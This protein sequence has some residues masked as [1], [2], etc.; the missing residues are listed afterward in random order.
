MSED[1]RFKY[2]EEMEAVPVPDDDDSEVKIVHVANVIPIRV[3]CEIDGVS[4]LVTG[5]IDYETQ[6]IDFQ[7]DFPHLEKLKSKTLEFLRWRSFGH[8]VAIPEVPPEVV[9]QFKEERAQ[10]QKS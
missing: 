4:T 7:G 3:T 6:Q 1:T 9:E 2:V 10:C 5:Y 8:D